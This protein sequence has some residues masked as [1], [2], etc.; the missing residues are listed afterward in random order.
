MDTDEAEMALSDV[1]Q[2][3]VSQLISA[4]TIDT[5][6]SATCSDQT[7]GSNGHS[8]RSSIV[9][10]VLVTPSSSASGRKRRQTSSDAQLSDPQFRSSCKKQF[11]HMSQNKSNTRKSLS[12]DLLRDVVRSEFLKTH[13]VNS[14][15]DDSNQRRI[16]TETN[17]SRV[18][19]LPLANHFI[20]D[21]ELY[22][23]L[24]EMENELNGTIASRTEHVYDNTL[25]SMN[26][27][28]EEYATFM[29]D[30]EEEMYNMTVRQY[31][32]DAIQAQIMDYYNQE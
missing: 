1:P 4:A 25:G 5:R 27:V 14:F 31:D 28:A 20:D 30:G 2:H 18:Q 16:N 26:N 15:L 21:D 12:I 24:M 11:I 9:A 19:Q 29:S 22:D 10:D 8:H 23:L 7:T 6:A 3:F 17:Y 13:N 32:D